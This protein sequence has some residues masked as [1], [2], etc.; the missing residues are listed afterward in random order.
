MNDPFTIGGTRGR[1]MCAKC[2]GVVYGAVLLTSDYYCLCHLKTLQ[3]N[4]FAQK[5]IGALVP[6]ER[7]ENYSMATMKPTLAE[8]YPDEYE[9]FCKLYG[10]SDEF[11]TNRK[12]AFHFFAKGYVKGYSKG[13]MDGGQKFHQ[14]PED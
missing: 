9:A 6:E 12:I 7:A 10:T 14:Y 8:Q 3:M 2:K 4:T 5:K 13:Y 1:I 11:P